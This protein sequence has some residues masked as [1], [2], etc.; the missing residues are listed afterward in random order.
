MSKVNDADD[1]DDA[2]HIRLTGFTLCE[3]ELCNAKSL[4]FYCEMII[5]KIR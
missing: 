2:Q 4:A 1:E 5:N 3:I